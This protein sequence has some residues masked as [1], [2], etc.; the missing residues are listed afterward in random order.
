MIKVVPRRSKI[1]PIAGP[2]VDPHFRDTFAYRSD[3]SGIPR[4]QPFD[5]DLDSEPVR[6]NFGLADPDHSSIAATRLHFINH[7]MPF[8]LVVLGNS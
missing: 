4:R 5:P 8:P 6:K 3:I 2:D 1:D 7:C